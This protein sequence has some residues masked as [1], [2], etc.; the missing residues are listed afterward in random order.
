[1]SKF[2]SI[3]HAIQRAPTH[4][5]KAGRS[6]GRSA[7]NKASALISEARSSL[8]QRDLSAPARNP[9]AVRFAERNEVRTMAAPPEL[10][11]SPKRVVSRPRDARVNISAHRAPVAV[12]ARTSDQ[13]ATDQVIDELEMQLE[14][15]ELDD[16]I[17]LSR[18]AM[19]AKPSNPEEVNRAFE[20]MLKQLDSEDL[21][22]VRQHEIDEVKSLLD[23]LDRENALK[24]PRPAA[25]PSIGAAKAA[26]ADAAQ[27]QLDDSTA[28]LTALLDGLKQDVVQRRTAHIAQESE[29]RSASKASVPAPTTTTGTQAVVESLDAQRQIKLPVFRRPQQP[30]MAE[31]ATLATEP[32]VESTR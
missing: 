20:D 3:K 16:A 28:E 5:A 18:Q 23:Q 7:S 1:M 14:I 9:R 4:I 26:A 10:T 31:A 15:A 25:A 19:A 22:A 17:D 8:G 24:D 29:M 32:V 12:R 30:L 21:E 27:A 11:A 2:S 13:I 6:I